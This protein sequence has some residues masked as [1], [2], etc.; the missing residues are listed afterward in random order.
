MIRSGLAADGRTDIEAGDQDRKLTVSL[1]ASVVRQL[2]VRMAADETTVR[3]LILEALA[4]TGYAVP[5]TEIRDR[6]RREAV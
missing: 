1:P 6:R 5:V 4:S 2:K 3:A